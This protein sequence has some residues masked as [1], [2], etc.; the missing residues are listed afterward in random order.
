MNH[1]ISVMCFHVAFCI[2]CY[3]SCPEGGRHQKLSCPLRVSFAGVSPPVDVAPEDD[4][5]K[6]VSVRCGFTAY[7]AFP[8][9]TMK[10]LPLTG[11][12]IIW[13]SSSKTARIVSS[14]TT[15]RGV[16]SRY[17]SPLRSANM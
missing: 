6:S 9:G 2:V 14:V 4:A 12:S 11:S 10:G 5:H 1:I 3:S 16:P 13:H 8:L 7:C 15:S 17:S